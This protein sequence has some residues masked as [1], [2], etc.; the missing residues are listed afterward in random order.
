[1]TKQTLQ[2]LDDVF[3]IHSFEQDSPIPAPVFSASVFFIAKTYEELSVVVPSSVQLKSQEVESDWRALEVLGPLGFSLT[4]IMSQISG[5][6]AAN[7][8][9]IFA[10]STFDTDY[11]L[12]KQ[13]KVQDAINALRADGYMVIEP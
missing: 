5:V 2:L 10:I 6:L 8:I 3:D 9:S 4:G 13:D 12:I 7:H 1:M 11:I